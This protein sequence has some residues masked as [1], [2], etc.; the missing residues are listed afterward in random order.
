VPRVRSH[1]GVELHYDLHDFTNPWEDAPT[2][3]LQHGFGRSGRFWFGTIPHL[4]RFYRLICPDF[5]GLGQ[6]SA[7]FDPAAGITVDNYLRD[8]ET[9]LDHAGVETVHYVG[10]S[11]GGTV[12][13][14]FAATR[15]AR[16]RTLS[17][18][19]SPIRINE[20]MREAYAAGHP[21]W[22]EAI[23]T[24]GSDGWARATNT[25]ARF[26]TD[27]DPRFLDWYSRGVGQSPTPVLAAMA[28]LALGVELEPLLPRIQTPLLAVFPSA[29]RIATTE[30]EE[31]LRRL[32]PKV[33]TVRLR[34]GSHMIQ[35]MEPGACAR[36]VLSFLALHDGRACDE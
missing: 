3:L 4:A 27:M 2:A 36:L 17:V 30:Q 15:P 26:P 13:Y 28:R 18:L 16:L 32:V 11:I 19:A 1:D 10:E 14:A 33:H 21:S 9:I 20:W 31:T 35:F 12:G 22:P 24:L 6:S 23:E 25:A 8:I 7:D 5:R 29:G 34:T